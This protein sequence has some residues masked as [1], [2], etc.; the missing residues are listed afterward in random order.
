MKPYQ[1]LSVG[2]AEPSPTKPRPVSL[3]RARGWLS[4]VLLAFC[5]ST[6]FLMAAYAADG[7]IDPSFITGPG[8]YAGVQNIPEIKGQAGYPTVSG[9]PYND[10]SLLFGNFGTVNVGSYS[11]IHN[12]IA[13][14]T[15]TGAL[16]ATFLNNQMLN[17]EIRGAFIYP[18]DYPVTTLRDKILIW[19]RFNASADNVQ[20]NNFAR[21][22]ADGTIDTSL[23]PVIFSW[24]GA[25]NTVAVQGPGNGAP[26]AGET[27][28]ILVGGYNLNT[29]E[30]NPAYQLVRLKYD[31]SLDTN[32][33]HWG[34]PGGYINN[35]KILP[36][37]DPSFPNKIRIFCS[38]PKNQDGTGGTYYVLVLEPTVTLPSP[39]NLPVAS[40][41]NETVDGPIFNWARQTDGKFLIGGE[42][43]H[44]NDVGAWVPRNRVARLGSDLRTL[45]SYDVGVGPNGPVTQISP[46]S[47]D[48][49]V[50]AGYF[51]TWNGAAC[52]Y[53]VRLTT[54]AAVDSSFNSGAGADDR[55]MHLN[56]N[57]NGSG[58]AIYG[59]FRNYNGQP[60]GGIAGLNGDGS[61]N[62]NFA[63][64]TAMAGWPGMVYSLATQSDGKILIGGYFNGVGGKYRDGFAR[65][66]PNGSLD[67]SFKG[68]VDGMV[69]SVAVQADGKILLGG[70]F[71]Q[72]QGYAC[73]SL[74]RLNPDG[75]LDTAFNPRL[76][77][78]DNCVNRV[79]QV[80]PLS[81][82]QIM[83]AGDIY[84]PGLCRRKR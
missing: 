80:V 36:S 39:S 41:G 60:R 65:L 21:L 76:V 5:L 33:T 44:V 49:M 1:L 4:L 35:I 68:G 11:P 7:D 8:P 51:T 67:T 45:D 18:H 63:N 70:E 58:G 56:W 3:P 82:G 62:G 77:G 31:G 53:L 59:Y 40:I 15:D 38:Y 26:L 34:A 84:N 32:F 23:T 64:V 46:T 25:I 54:T 75:S 47:D 29:G 61:F 13:R 17:G 43:K 83:I 72:C 14:L 73:T 50:L 28:K 79:N 71:G 57:Y 78:V 12:C 81:N 16:D 30:N 27:D 24:G 52:G 2:P 74:A 20:Y 66:N 48:R 10:Y 69:M 37:D 55:I 6:A 42:F 22:K 19:G 9:S